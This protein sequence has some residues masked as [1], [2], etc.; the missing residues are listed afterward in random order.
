MGAVWMAIKRSPK[1]RNAGLKYLN[2]NIPRKNQDEE[3]ETS[4]N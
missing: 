4:A 2:K 1:T 3:P